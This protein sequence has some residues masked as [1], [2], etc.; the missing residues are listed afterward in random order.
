MSSHKGWSNNMV[1]FVAVLMVVEQQQQ[2]QHLQ[3]EE[4]VSYM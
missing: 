1:G 3:Q 4:K 2:Q